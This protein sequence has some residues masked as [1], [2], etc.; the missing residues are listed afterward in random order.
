VVHREGLA[1]RLER[2]GFQV[3]ANL[4]A[5]PALGLPGWGWTVAVGC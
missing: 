2:P 4:G 5:E 1:L 3:V